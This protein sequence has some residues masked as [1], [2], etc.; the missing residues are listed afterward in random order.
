[1][2]ATK[3]RPI[4]GPKTSGLTLPR[5]FDVDVAAS[6]HIYQGAMTARDMGTTGRPACPAVGNNLNKIVHGFAELEADNSAGSQGDKRVG[7]VVTP[8][9]VANSGAGVDQITDAD[10]FQPAYVVDD[11]TVG[12]TSNSGARSVA[13]LI[14]DVDSVY[15][16]LIWP[17]PDVC[18][19]NLS[20][21][22]APV[23]FST[24]QTGTGAS[25]NVA[26]GLGI[27][28]R[29]VVVWPTDLTPATVGSY[30]VVEGTHA[31]TNVVLT[32]TSGKKFKVFAWA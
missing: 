17:S 1:M 14:L 12:R 26:H 29:G 7:I 9:W 22:R 16:V 27:K 18:R 10:L 19:A 31:A 24:E 11:I 32:V 21:E 25:Q 15:G 6:T 8:G 13:G 2:A 20:S 28:P 30:S 4:T 3:N 23:F 5:R